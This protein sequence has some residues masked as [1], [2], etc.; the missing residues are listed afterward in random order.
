MNHHA[1][2][3]P[4]PGKRRRRWLVQWLARLVADGL[5]NREIAGCD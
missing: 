5:A 4:R 2:K 3:S 1:E